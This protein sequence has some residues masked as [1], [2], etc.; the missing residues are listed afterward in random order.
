MYD[1]TVRVKITTCVISFSPA[2][3]CSKAQVPQFHQPQCANHSRV[4]CDDAHWKKYQYD[5]LSC[6]IRLCVNSICADLPKNEAHTFL[7]LAKK[8]QGDKRIRRGDSHGS[9]NEASHFALTEVANVN[10]SMAA[11]NDRAAENVSEA[12]VTHTVTSTSTGVKF[13]FILIF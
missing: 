7:F 1:H 3:N 12:T 4:F 9:T 8:R 13:F 2:A 10:V 5:R 11:R 6:T